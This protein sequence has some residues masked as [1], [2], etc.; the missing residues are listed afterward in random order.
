MAYK[1]VL[2]VATNLGKVDLAMQGAAAL[3][4]Q[5]A[6]HLEVLALGVDTAHVGYASV[7]AGVRACPQPAAHRG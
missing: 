6:A 1:S 3:C 5:Q 2:T 7:G 4:R